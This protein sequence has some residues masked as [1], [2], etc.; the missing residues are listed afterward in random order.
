[1]ADKLIIYLGDSETTVQ[2]AVVNSNTHAVL[3]EGRGSLEQIADVARGNPVLA[4]I[5]SSE[6]LLTEV[7]VPTRNT[8]KVRIA[9]PNLLEE[10]LSE[11]IDDLHCAIGEHHEGDIYPVGIIAVQRIEY[12]QR[13]LSD[14]GI[15]VEALMP[16][17]LALPYA[18]KQWSA[19]QEADEVIV[20]ESEYA[21]FSCAPDN[22]ELFFKQALKRREGADMPLVRTFQDTLNIPTELGIEV[23][24]QAANNL[25][26]VF[27]QGIQQGLVINL[28]QGDYKPQRKQ[29]PAWSKWR[30]TALL[31]SLLLGLW[32]V[33]TFQE[34]YQLKTANERLTTEIHQI[35]SQAF[36]G[37]RIVNPR[38]QM[39][40]KLAALKGSGA[41][42][43]GDFLS[44]LSQVSSSVK[45]AADT[46]LKGLAFRKG[47][48]DFD[49]Q[50][51][52]LKSLEV[53]RGTLPGSEVITAK[54]EEGVVNGRI[55]VK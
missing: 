46:E 50:V 53:L 22:V 55:R 7:H 20:R 32:L 54:S 23:D 44:A 11:D 2:W 52:D 9:A 41:Q 40:Q 17:V 36:P 33:A 13:L 35:Y 26:Q 27:S 19:L 49:V 3:K 37:S 10:T 30:R 28:L 29:N 47:R 38:A 5:P 25:L 18:D 4:L 1:M 6:V 39:K 34:A 24:L 8:S 14:A 51:K 31:A 48:L 45:N 21:G 15:A 12:Y 42:A 16:S 43:E